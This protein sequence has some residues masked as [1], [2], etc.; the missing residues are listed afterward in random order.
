M[1]FGMTSKW[2]RG[3]IFTNPL[4][5]HS[6]T[7][8]QKR[9][10]RV[11]RQSRT[12]AGFWIIRFGGAECLEVAQ[13]NPGLATVGRGRATPR[14]TRDSDVRRPLPDAWLCRKR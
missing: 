12:F 9:E 14:D 2:G 5:P 8:T 11:I 1:T 3:D 6:R 10:S 7:T 13:R 4:H